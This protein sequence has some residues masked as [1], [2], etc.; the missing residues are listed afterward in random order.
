MFCSYWSIIPNIDI[1]SVYYF[2]EPI[3]MNI[4]I[5]G[6]GRIG[7]HALKVALQKKG[8]TVV[9]INDLADPAT[10]AH[11]FTYDTAYGMTNHT[12]S[13]EEGVMVID[14]KNKIQMFAERDPSMLPWKKLKVD[15]VLECTGVFR[16]AQSAS[17]HLAAGAKKVI[18]SAPSKGDD[19]DGYVRGV[20]C[21]SYAG[22]EIIDTASC[23]TNCTAPVAKIIDDEFGIEKAMLT[24][25]HSY[26]A[27][28]NLQDGPHKD[29]RRARA[30]AENIVPTSTGAAEATTKILPQLHGK[31]DGLA[32]RVPTVTGS[33][34]DFVF[35]L[36]RAV[37]VDEVND[38]LRAAAKKKAWKGIFTVSEAPL[39]STDFIG[40]SHSSI[41]DLELTRV[42]DGTL[43]KVIAWYDNEWGYANRLVEMA[44]KVGKK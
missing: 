41:A 17:A 19:I 36:K 27:D 39:V 25:I 38:A 6:F 9:A 12:V 10:L 1:L 13:V 40:N 5:N 4:A 8:L 34:T 23:T 35:L 20:N 26:T 29:L 32:V 18:I 22:A 44:E 16:D 37:T 15:V 14:K 42:V 33:L 21:D 7:R 30:A 28:Q 11:L 3:R 2:F 24:T 31:F 43:V